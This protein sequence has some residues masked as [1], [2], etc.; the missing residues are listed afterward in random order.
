MTSYLGGRGQPGK[1][2]MAASV[3]L[4]SNIGANLVLIPMY[5]IVGAALS[6]VV[7]YTTLAVLVVLMASRVSGV[8][9]ASLCIPKPSD[10]AQLATSSLTIARRGVARVRAR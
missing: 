2:S 9:P 5:G 7:S 3:A 6:S 8:S 4:V 1:I 10:A